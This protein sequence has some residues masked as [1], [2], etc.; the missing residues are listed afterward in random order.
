MVVGQAESTRD[1]L[2]ELGA[3]LVG[4]WTGQATVDFDLEGICKKG[5][6][7][8][9]LRSTEWVLDKLA[10]IRKSTF[11]VDGKQVAQ[12]AA[13]VTW[14]APKKQ[15]RALY[16]DSL[17]STISST[18]RKRGSSWV[19][20]NRGVVGDGRKL[21]SKVVVKGD[22]GGDTYTAVTTDRILGEESVP[23]TKVTFTRVK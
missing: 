4:E 9:I 17:G 16:T 6:T 19:C 2:N 14:S 13:L 15:I 18:W 1:S 20:L 10:L 7:V 22:E 5:D 23:D 12:G 3:V 21:S 8:H 11:T